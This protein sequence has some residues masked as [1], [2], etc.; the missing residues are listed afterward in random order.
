MRSGVQGPYPL[1]T[2]RNHFFPDETLSALAFH[3]GYMNKDTV[4][5]KNTYRRKQ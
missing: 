2:A 4:Q 5:L 1:E 3:E